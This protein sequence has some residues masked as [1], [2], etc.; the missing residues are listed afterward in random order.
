MGVWVIGADVLARG[1]FTVSAMAE[2]VAALIALNGGGVQPGREAWLAGHA[3]AFR[4][5]LA[6]DPVAELFVRTALRPTWLPDFL[7]TPP[8]PDDLTF[9][10]ELRRLRRTPAETALADACHELEGPPP[11]GLRVPDLTDR[12]AALLAWVWTRAVRPEWPR[13][14]R[15][16][17]ADVVSRTQALSSGGWAAA[18]NGMRPGMRW[19]GDGRLRIN[20]YA[21]PPRELPAAAR[22]MFIP[23]TAR[24]GWV[25]WDAWDEPARARYA[26]TYP[27]SGLLAEPPA[28]A[29]S[30]P[31]ARLLGPLRAAIL[32]D[33]ATP[34]ST[35]QLAALTGAALG[36]VGAHLR[37]L[38]EA[39]LL[40]RRRS[41]RVVLYYRTELGDRLAAAAT[42]AATS[43]M[44]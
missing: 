44:R 39:G 41:G 27:C 10:D 37:I 38:R 25:A 40:H 3:P 14:R 29:A 5:R 24:R 13:L 43:A 42:S 31:L 36:S 20:A 26:V 30:Q 11:P 6:A 9:D 17:E 34:K 2:T 32:A 15:V 4:E 12:V 18:L 7:T 28:T 33:L 1:R 16:F 35:T 23:A 21:Y 8:L 19:L 22:L